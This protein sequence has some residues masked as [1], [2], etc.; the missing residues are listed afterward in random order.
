MALDFSSLEGMDEALGNVEEAGLDFSEFDMP[1]ALTD[2]EL[3]QN[4]CDDE[5]YDLDKALRKYLAK[6][7]WRRRRDGGFKTSASLVFT[8]LFGRKPTQSDT[9][10]TR[11]LNQLL[12]YYA[13]RCSKGH[14]RVNNKQYVRVY[15]F[16]KYAS[17]NKRPYSLRLRME[18]AEADGKG[19]R[20]TLRP[21]LDSKGKPNREGGSGR[22]DTGSGSDDDGRG[23]T[24]GGGPGADDDEAGMQGNC[25]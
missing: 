23:S 14:A 5:L 18:E 25:G 21:N 12:R 1:I 3:W 7:K 19:F 2:Y 24:P 20:Y 4:Y 16:S 15:Y 11:K 6:Q 9:R 17:D 10:L 22:G 8:Y 13:T